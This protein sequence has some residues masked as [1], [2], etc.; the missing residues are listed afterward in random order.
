MPETTDPVAAFAK[1]VKDDSGSSDALRQAA[2]KL[3]RAL[4]KKDEPADK[5]A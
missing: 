5:K 2:G 3:H 1:A 4:S